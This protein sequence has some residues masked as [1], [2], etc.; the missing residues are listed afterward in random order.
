MAHTE[1]NLRERR[2]IDDMLNAK[3][4]VDKIAAEMAPHTA[5]LKVCTMLL[6]T[7]CY[8]VASCTNAA[9]KALEGASIVSTAAPALWTPCWRPTMRNAACAKA[10]VALNAR[11]ARSARHAPNA[12]AA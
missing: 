1:L 4:S 12:R 6:L 8:R 2:A 11:I 10:R 9:L 7:T 3:M 5:R